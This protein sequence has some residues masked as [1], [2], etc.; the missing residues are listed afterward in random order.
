MKRRLMKTVLATLVVG[1]VSVGTASAAPIVVGQWTWTE[2]D[3]GLGPEAVFTVTNFS[4]V[5]AEPA[6]DLPPIVPVPSGWQPGDFTNIF[7]T[8]TPSGSCPVALDCS[9]TILDI[10]EGLSAF[11]LESVDSS[12]VASATLTLQFLGQTLTSTINAAGDGGLLVYEFTPTQ[13]PEPASL[14]LVS[15]GSAAWFA[16]R[17]RRRP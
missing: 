8:L 13:V 3:F 2:E 7:V 10:D 11:N 9:V 14:A 6:Q 12:A 15:L 1:F 17:R 5:P 4:N 16:K